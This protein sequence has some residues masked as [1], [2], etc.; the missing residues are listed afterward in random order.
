MSVNLSIPLTP[1]GWQQ[2]GQPGNPQ[3][4]IATDPLSGVGV[5]IPF[6]TR[7]PA[8]TPPASATCALQSSGIASNSDGSCTGIN[9]SVACLQRHAAD[10]EDLVPLHGHIPQ[11]AMA[12]R[13]HLGCVLV[14]RSTAGRSMSPRK[15]C[16][17]NGRAAP[18]QRW[19]EPC[20]HLRRAPRRYRIHHCVITL[21]SPAS[22]TSTLAGLRTGRRLQGGISCIAAAM[23]DDR[24]DR[25][26]H[27]LARRRE[28][29]VEPQYRQG[30]SRAS[31]TATTTYPASAP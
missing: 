6:E 26:P 16:T 19:R 13:R 12:R 11:T 25:E 4:F 31:T 5:S 3:G 17:L 24:V 7:R 9:M 1:Y 30:F 22:G 8:W 18:G 20:P 21:P 14:A 28:S 2:S 29:R 23:H 27:R 15:T 10:G